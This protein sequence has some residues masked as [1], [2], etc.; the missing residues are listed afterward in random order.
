MTCNSLQRSF[1]L[2]N[3]DGLAGLDCAVA[4][5]VTHDLCAAALDELGEIG[6]VVLGACEHDLAAERPLL[7]GLAGLHFL[8]GLAQVGQNE[9]LRAN[10]GNKLD[11]MELV[12]GDGRVLKLAVIAD[13]VYELAD[14]IVLLDSFLE[15]L[16]RDVD[17]EVFMQRSQDMSLELIMVVFIVSLGVFEGNV[18]ELAEEFIVLDDVHVLDGVK[19]LGLDVLLEAAGDGA[20]L[21]RHLGIEEVEAALECALEKAASVVTYASGHI[22]GR[23]VGR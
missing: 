7:V 9:I 17:A 1:A 20:G 11:N 4:V 3:G 15:R 2:L 8:C 12:A 5:T 19:M 6:V 13:L 23:Y 21:G 18:G 14:L 10:E 22:V 16:V